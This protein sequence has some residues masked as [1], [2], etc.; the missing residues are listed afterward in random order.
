MT[1]ARDANHQSLREVAGRLTARLGAASAAVANGESALV[2]A[3]Q[4]LP[5][6]RHLASSP[7]SP[8]YHWI[9]GLMPTVW[10][11]LS[12]GSVSVTRTVIAPRVGRG[13]SV[14]SRVADEEMQG[15]LEEM[16]GISTVLDDDPIQEED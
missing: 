14:H 10:S 15:L 8:H 1:Q 2:L 11:S 6:L 16:D 13:A 5:Y 9:A 7:C 4:V 3:T 12:N